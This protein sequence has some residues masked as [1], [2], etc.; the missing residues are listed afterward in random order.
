MSERIGFTWSGLDK[1]GAGVARYEVNGQVFHLE[2]ASVS[3]ALE[4]R[5]FLKFVFAS[6][7]T[8][9]YG[10]VLSGQYGEVL[11]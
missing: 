6:G 11:K 7:M 1:T 10:E 3:E 8:C 9:A 4:L 2:R 5:D